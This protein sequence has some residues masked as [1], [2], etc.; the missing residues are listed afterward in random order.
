VPLSSK[1]LVASF[2]TADLSAP[3]DLEAFLREAGDPAPEVMLK[4]LEAVSA[5]GAE[6][7]FPR[8]RARCAAFERLVGRVPDKALFVPMVNALKGGDATL[9]TTLMA[10]IPAVNHVGKHEELCQLLRSGDATVRQVGA[11]VLGGLG[12][13]TALRLL[14]EWVEEA[15]FPGR[16]EAVDAL[17]RC[18]GHH[19]IP[20][21]KGALFAGNA[22]EQAHALRYLGDLKYVAKGS[23]D[24]LQVIA[25][26]LLEKRP[27][28][29][30]PAVAAFCKLCSEED[31]F[32]A[33]AP[34]L[35]VDEVD[36]VRAAVEGLRSFSSPRTFDALERK[37]LAGPNTI[38][39]V[40][41]GTLEAIGTDD[42]IP[43]LVGAIS[44]PQQAVRN[45]ASEALQNLSRSGKI[46]LARTI[47]WLAHSKDVNVRRQAVELARATNDQGDQLWPRLLRLLR[48]EDWWVRESVAEAVVGMAGHKL[49]PHI[50][51]YLNDPSDV[52]RRF[53]IELLMRLDDP[54]SLT[55]LLEVAA[56]DADWWARERAI[57]AAAKLKDQRAVPHLVALLGDREVQLRAVEGLAAL[58]AR[59]ASR[60][61]AALAAS[62]DPDVRVVVAKCLAGFDDRGLATDLE[63]MLGDEDIRVREVARDALS[64]WRSVPAE[65]TRRGPRIG[66]LLEEIGRSG[67]DDL[68]VAVGHPPTMKKMGRATPMSGEPLTDAQTR[69]LLSS[70]LKKE[71]LKDLEER[72]DAD[73]SYA[74]EGLR[75]RVNAYKAEG[76]LCAV[77]RIIRGRLLDFDALGLPEV[78][79]RFADLKNGLVVIGGPTGSGKSTTLA[80]LIDHITR[81][82][83]QH[84]VTLED[85]VEVVYD[86]RKCLVNQRE[87]GVHAL[88]FSSGLRGALRQDPNVLL[89]GEMRDL[90]TIAAAVSAAETGH[91]V[92]GTLHTVSVDTSVDRLINVFPAI[93]QDQVRAM[94]AESLR[95]VACQYLL[96]RRDTPGRVLALEIMLCNDAVSNLIRKG[97]TFQIPSV[98]AS[99]VEL[100]M[101]TMDS[102]LMGLFK[103]G[104]ISAEDAYMKARSKSDFE[105]ILAKEDE[106]PSLPSLAPLLGAGK[107]DAEA[108][109][110][111]EARPPPPEAPAPVPEARPIVALPPPPSPPTPVPEVRHATPAPP[112]PV[113]S[114]PAPP[115]PVPVVPGPIPGLPRLVRMVPQ[116]APG[117]PP[118]PA[119]NVPPPRVAPPA[120]P[121]VPP[122]MLEAVTS[123]SLPVI[124]LST[125]PVQ[126]PA[127][128]PA[129]LP[130]EE[131]TEPQLSTAG[132]DLGLRPERAE[133]PEEP[134]GSSDDEARA[135]WATFAGSEDKF[136]AGPET[137][138]ALESIIARDSGCA[139]AHYFVG[140]VYLFVGDQLNARVWFN[141]TLEVDPTHGAARQRLTALGS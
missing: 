134:A 87:I 35:D 8:H 57:E 99:S 23:R 86:A 95:A 130:P 74:Y 68:L 32:V 24:A 47:I 16:I 120:A 12:G 27:P 139:T 135:V 70:V 41:I 3:R 79:R 106:A 49:T 82:R 128:F 80:A 6:K 126:A 109:A 108:E 97:K 107:P 137:V 72:G 123:D 69:E 85:P 140:Q 4:L 83:S 42:V 52:I 50:L 133:A 44:H 33:I 11:Q 9:R 105:A 56:R 81:H 55:P 64:R 22:E 46:D 138:T 58:G 115:T 14:G 53:A 54:R 48:D 51:P 75:F 124:E 93:Q 34:Y 71:Q 37:L 38:R 61:I 17:A 19:A 129:E 88:S 89:V 119:A 112:A 7:D 67:A 59:G 29:L 20:A 101:R 104:R 62:D 118:G 13:K 136:A 96:P 66:M 132:L 18:A 43:V 113:A 63:A 122:P 127:E 25:E 92:F 125:P 31:Y 100:G 39:F 5:R 1:E 91:L 90:P 36:V 30:A 77:F 26:F 141:K 60:E 78:V 121:A 117:R 21:L 102:E 110:E 111:A 94:L 116:A 131:R 98:L 73:F 40:V 2:R 114:T 65:G 28:Q 76:G 103:A 10:L 84:I 45:R 15:G